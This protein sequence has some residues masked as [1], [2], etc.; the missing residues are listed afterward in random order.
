MNGGGG[1]FKNEKTKKEKKKEKSLSLAAQADTDPQPLCTSTVLLNARLWSTVPQCR[2]KLRCKTRR[3]D[4]KKNAH[5][6]LRAF[7]TNLYFP[8]LSPY[9]FKESQQA[10]VLILVIFGTIR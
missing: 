1:E 5:H 3:A 7:H 6:R 10:S 8:F 2:S 4:T 9:N